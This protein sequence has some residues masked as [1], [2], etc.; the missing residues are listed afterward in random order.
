MSISTEIARL[1]GA[2]ADLKSYLESVGITVSDDT[3]I[4]GMVDLLASIAQP[5]D[6]VVEQGYEN[7]WRYRKWNSGVLEQWYVGY[8]SSISCSTAWGNVYTTSSSTPVIGPH[9]YY[10]PFVTK[11]PMVQCTLENSSGGDFWL[12]SSAGGSMTQ[13]PGYRLGRGTSTTG[14]STDYTI[15]AVGT[16]K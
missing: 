3:L 12:I 13:T 2:K 4:D 7:Y 11:K 8:K 9:D 6:Y 10:I 14:G 16:W 5:A 15:Y 1:Q